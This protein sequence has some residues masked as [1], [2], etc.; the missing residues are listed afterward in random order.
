MLN[1]YR[2]NKGL[3]KFGPLKQGLLLINDI[4][5]LIRTI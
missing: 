1:K 4:N 3:R 5:L 2:R